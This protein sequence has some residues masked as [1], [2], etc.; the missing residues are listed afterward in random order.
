MKGVV[1]MRIIL[2]CFSLV[3]KS[4]YYVLTRFLFPLSFTV[5]AVDIG[6]QVR[7]S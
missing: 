2:Q 7:K 4:D 6:E 1:K 5:I 3:A